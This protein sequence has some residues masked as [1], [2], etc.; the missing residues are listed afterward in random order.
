MVAPLEVTERGFRDM[1]G[2]NRAASAGGTE[3]GVTG[4]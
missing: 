4:Y 2:S 3:L 1:P